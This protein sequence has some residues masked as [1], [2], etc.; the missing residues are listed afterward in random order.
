MPLPA[1]KSPAAASRAGFKI[2]VTGICGFAGSVIVRS[3]LAHRTGLRIS[4]IDNLTRRGSETN[5]ELL[6]E[7]GCEIHIADIRDRK[8]LETLAPADWI[9]DC[10]ANPSV[11]AGVD[12]S[13][14]RDLVDQNLY[15][16]VNLLELCKTWKAGFTLLSTS[17]V[18]SIPELASLPIAPA[19]ERF[20]LT[21]GAA[22]PGWSE[23]GIAEDFSI[24]PPVSLYGSTKLC[25]E[26]LA[27]E[28]GGAF[29]FPVWINRC[30]VLAGGGQF[31]K[32]DQG[33]FSYW[34]HSW[35][36]KRPLKYIGFGGS[37]LQVRDCLHPRDLSPLLLA[38]IDSPS[39]GKPRTVNLAGGIGNSMS[40]R[41]LSGWCAD[42][43]GPAPRLSD[44][45]HISTDRSGRPFDI[46][47]AVLDSSLAA[48]AWG[49]TPST[50]LPEILEEIRAHSELNPEW[51]QLVAD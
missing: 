46:P 50:T 35:N 26:W 12:G 34:I 3:L 25:S 39:E 49:W 45:A 18:Y 33:I 1:R 15:G 29:G 5:L 7:L 44:P 48:S 20:A 4:G 23:R 14:S 10:A 2:F 42:A 11:L 47:W 13:P 16:T 22:G 31:G 9:I 51:L 32:A 30:G 8:F 40:L 17:R 37:G 6:R 43:F 28:Y 21:P 36:A 41:E 38:Q 19:G 27:L 24:A